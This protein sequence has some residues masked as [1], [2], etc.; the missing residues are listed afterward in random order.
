MELTHE[1]LK[2]LIAYYG[3]L[4]DWYHYRDVCYMDYVRRELCLE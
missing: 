3:L 2:H 1:A 4:N